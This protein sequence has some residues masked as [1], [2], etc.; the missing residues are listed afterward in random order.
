MTDKRTELPFER[1]EDMSPEERTARA[2]AVFNW[3][4]GDL[5]FLYER[6]RYWFP[7]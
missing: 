5:L 7:R 4:A 2:E 6:P 3:K 1:Y